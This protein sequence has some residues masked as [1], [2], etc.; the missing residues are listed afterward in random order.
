MHLSSVVGRRENLLYNA[1]QTSC[2]WKVIVMQTIDNLILK[3]FFYDK[4]KIKSIGIQTP[5]LSNTCA[6]KQKNL[7]HNHIDGN[8]SYMTISMEW[9][10]YRM[11][12]Y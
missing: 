9:A 4:G 3:K 2:L 12:N 7:T 5:H 6:T 1:Q 8:L 11:G 10:K